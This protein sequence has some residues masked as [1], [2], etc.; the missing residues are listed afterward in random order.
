M[1]KSQQGSRQ[2]LLKLR[3]WHSWVRDLMLGL[4]NVEKHLVFGWHYRNKWGLSLLV[5]TKWFCSRKSCNCDWLSNL[6]WIIGLGNK[7][8]GQIQHFKYGRCGL[9]TFSALKTHLFAGSGYIF[10]LIPPHLKC[11]VYLL[12]LDTNGDE[13]DSN[14]TITWSKPLVLSIINNGNG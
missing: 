6:Y 2:K 12:H 11:H 8:W 14:E 13:D 5:L 1:E 7:G 10:K 9:N 4:G 3:W